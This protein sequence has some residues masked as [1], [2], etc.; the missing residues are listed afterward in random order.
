MTLAGA[1]NTCS[2]LVSNFLTDINGDVLALR[3]PDS[4]HCP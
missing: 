2:G 1:A 4:R 3:P